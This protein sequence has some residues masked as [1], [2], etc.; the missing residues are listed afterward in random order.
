MLQ[1]KH[2]AIRRCTTEHMLLVTSFQLEVAV[3]GKK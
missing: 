3:H 1:V 2:L